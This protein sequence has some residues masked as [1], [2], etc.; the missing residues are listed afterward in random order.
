MKSTKSEKSNK[1]EY[2]YATKKP[3]TKNQNMTNGENEDILVKVEVRHEMGDESMH[4][5]LVTE[6]KERNQT[7]QSLQNGCISTNEWAVDTIK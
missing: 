1:T 2:T 5:L 3:K 7:H 6:C 4:L